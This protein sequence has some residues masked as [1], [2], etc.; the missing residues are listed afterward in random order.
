MSQ[1]LR[2]TIASG[3]STKL[4]V[5]SRD[6]ILRNRPALRCRETSRLMAALD[7]NASSIALTQSTALRELSR[8][9]EA[10]QAPA[11][12]AGI[13]KTESVLSNET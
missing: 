8:F 9:W 5:Y 10:L 1:R 7:T 6:P 12:K 13:V 11:V 3:S 2:R 4:V